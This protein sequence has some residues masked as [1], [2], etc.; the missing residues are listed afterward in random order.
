MLAIVIKISIL[1]P[2][3]GGESLWMPILDFEWQKQ[4]LG[5]QSL[6]Y[7]YLRKEDKVGEMIFRIW[8][9]FLIFSYIDKNNLKI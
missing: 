8:R 4:H 5:F 3:Y 1:T 2:L 7:A 9:S 6:V